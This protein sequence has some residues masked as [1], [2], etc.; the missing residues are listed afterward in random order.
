MTNILESIAAIIK[1]FVDEEPKPHLHVGEVMDLWIAFTAFHEAHALYQVGLNT[2][3]DPDLKHVLKK[4]LA[5]SKED[6]LRIGNFLLKEGVPLPLINPKKPISKP[7]AVPEGVKLNDDEIANLISV[8]VAT[9][10]TFC[11]QAM[12]KT[13][14]TDVGLMF[15]LIQVN[16]M[17]FGAPLKNLMK[18]KG[19]LRIPPKYYPP[20]SPDN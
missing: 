4:A 9:S 15:F 12:S 13:I 3:T 11:A 18:E 19:W 6:T 7:D 17:K 20:G 14:R 8:K 2:T 16:L 5:G 10:I 1:N